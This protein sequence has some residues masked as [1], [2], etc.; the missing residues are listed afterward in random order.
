MH[1]GPE[2]THRSPVAVPLS[3]LIVG[4]GPPAMT[5]ADLSARHIGTTATFKVQGSTAMVSGQIAGIRHSA[6]A[7]GEDGA[8]E[9]EYTLITIRGHV[10]IKVS[11]DATIKLGATLGE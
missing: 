4:D 6:H 3:Q 9:H 10:Q 7:S 5:A 11:P 2:T 1:I 8:P